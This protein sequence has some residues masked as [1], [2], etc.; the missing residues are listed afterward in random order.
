MASIAANDKGQL[1]VVYNQV[2][3][4]HVDCARDLIP[5]RTVFAVSSD[6]GRSWTSTLVGPAWW[7]FGSAGLNPIYG[8]W[9]GEFQS[10]TGTPN[11]FT[12]ITP[13]GRA[14]TPRPHPP[15]VGE[16]GIVVADIH[17]VQGRP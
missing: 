6:R 12:T 11:G 14:L 5:A 4:T 3:L 15:I 10:L 9:L 16:T 8:W 7:N 13:Q 17:T 1:G 2:D